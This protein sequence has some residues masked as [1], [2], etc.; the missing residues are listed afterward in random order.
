MRHATRPATPVLL[1][2]ALL[3]A[4]TACSKFKKPTPYSGRPFLTGA[5]GT[6]AAGAGSTDTASKLVGQWRAKTES[7]EL[8]ADGTMLINGQ[9]HT[10]AVNENTLFVQGPGGTAAYPFELADEQLTVMLNGQPVVYT[11][12][13]EPGGAP[14]SL[15]PSNAGTPAST[16]VGATAGS[17]LPELAGKW[18]YMSNVHASDGGRQ[19][20]TCFTLNA[21][22]TYVYHSET[23]S[24]GAYGGTASQTDD[25]GRWA[26]TADTLTATSTS[27]KVTSYRFEKRNHPKTND[28]MLVFDG[29]SF[30]TYFQK[31]PW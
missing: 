2:F 24:S 10:Y 31:P 16:P 30:V 6:P 4:T 15:A 21:D 11:R 13:P 7:I 14:A 18:C 28:P 5:P 19:S 25:S 29:Q 12:V 27:G 8:R 22:G 3:S 9:A 20:N 26:A 23:S 1:L 17:V